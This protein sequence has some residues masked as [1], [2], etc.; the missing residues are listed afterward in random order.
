MA[1]YIHLGPCLYLHLLPVGQITTEAM[2]NVELASSMRPSDNNS[3]HVDSSSLPSASAVPAP[4]PKMQ[5]MSLFDHYSQN[6]PM[7]SES[8]RQEK[9]LQLYID[10]I[11]CSSFSYLETKL[12]DLLSKLDFR[13]I[14]HLFDN[15][16]CTPAR[17]LLKGCF[18]KVVC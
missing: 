1:L 5:R 18:P 10:T 14:S 15:I 16:F 17:P 4:Q 2:L 13:S 11:N 12:Q 8:N 6:R 7:L 3:P 9:Q